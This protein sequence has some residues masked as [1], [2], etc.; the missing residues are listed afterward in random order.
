MIIITN[1]WM[2]LNGLLVINDINAL[3]NTKIHHYWS[4]YNS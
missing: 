1:G 4:I 2:F 3:T